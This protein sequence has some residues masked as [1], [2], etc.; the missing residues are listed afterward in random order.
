MR[1]AG[2]FPDV[3]IEEWKTAA[4]SALRGADP[5]SLVSSTYE[6]LSVEPLYH[7]A[8]SAHLARLSGNVG[9]SPHIRGRRPDPGSRPWT[10]IQLL[11]HIDPAEAN[12]RLKDDF[13]NG[14]HGF[15]LQFAGNAR[16]SGGFLGARKL[17]AL[18]TVFDGAALDRMEL[19]LSGTTEAI[20]AAALLTAFIEKTG[21][22]P[23]RIRGS[24]CLD[25]LSHFAAGG[26][27]PALRTCVIAD[28][29]DAATYFRESGYGWTP[30]LVSAR[31]W[32]QAGGSAREEL[33]FALAA[34]VAYWRGLIEAGWPLD[35]AAG[36]IAFSLPADADLFMNIAKL[37]AMRALWARVTEAA[38][39]APMRARIVSEMSLRIMTERD[40]HVNM[41]RATATAFSAG[42]G[43][44]D[45]VLLIP[46]NACYAMPDAFA[47][48]MARNTQLILQEEAMLG[49]VAD[50]AGGSAYTETLT[51][52]LAGAAW[53]LFRRT[54]A[55]GGL[56]AAL[57]SGLVN[58]ELTD[59]ALRRSRNIAHNRDKLTGTTSYPN[60]EE[61]IVYS[62]PEDFAIDLKA[63]EEETP[64]PA[65]PCPNRGKRFAAMVEAATKG[66]TLKG[67]EETAKRL[68]ERIDYIP[69]SRRR[70]AEPFERLR[71]ASDRA[72]SRIKTRPPVFLAN[73]G[74]LA[75]YTARASWV[76]NFLGAGGIQALDQGGFR[77]L[78]DLIRTFQR[79]PAPVA[80][81]CVAPSDLGL[82]K[83]A[84][85]ALKEAGASAV[86]FAGEAA[87]L[88]RI[89][90]PD[91]LLIDRIIYE[92]C[93]MI[94]VLSELHEIM[95]VKELGEAELEEFEDEESAAHF[96]QRADGVIRS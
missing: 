89:E 22:P 20:P 67:L 75:N 81:I 4:R 41:L 72:Y 7:A 92:G 66:A 8:L 47:R 69:S 59:C 55:E 49:R 1:W 50:P 88:P 77:K 38:G 44:A 71:Q 63:L 83:G 95:G 85:A 82:M 61:D 93:D 80:C 70:D 5:D 84:P 86:Y 21:V 33:A 35:D 78:D 2:Q 90:Q 23:G 68:T 64:V 3:S 48:R 24:A 32:H 34:A 46:Y 87:L 30:F 43:G 13:Q 51:H 65:L 37:R 45:A 28:A 60:L 6:G 79:S 26:F 56:L 31:A 18:D 11:D 91:R 73:L 27:V 42:A 25:P 74:P 62:R 58:R 16:D 53:E 39:L 29:V 54:E 9:A 19:Y 36:A 57:E 10:L 40:A 14:V 15:W 17:S 52:E 76:Q 94:A 96:S 12:R